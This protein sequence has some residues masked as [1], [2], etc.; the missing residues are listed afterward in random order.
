MKAASDDASL[1]HRPPSRRSRCRLDVL[2]ITDHDELRGARIAQEFAREHPELGVDVIVGEEI[3]T[4]NGH[5]LGLWLT[6]R[7]PPGL[8]ALETIARIRR[9]WTASELTGRAT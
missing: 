5:L 2:A 3:S 8:S 9:S 6:E 7:V 4:R 1:P